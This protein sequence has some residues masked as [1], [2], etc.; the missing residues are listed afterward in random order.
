MGDFLHH[1]AGSRR[2]G[3]LHDLVKLPEAEGTHGGA[4]A[5][6]AADGA[7]HERQLQ[8]FGFGHQGVSGGVG[9][10]DVGSDAPSIAGSSTAAGD[11]SGVSGTGSA[12]GA[13]ARV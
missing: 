7:A 5:F 3:L 10:S 2:V 1:P 4:L 11:A 13:A 8:G 6:G 9:G 12:A